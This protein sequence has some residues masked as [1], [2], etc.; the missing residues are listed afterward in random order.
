MDEEIVWNR[1][2]RGLAFLDTWSVIRQDGSIKTKV[3][4]KETH[5]SQYLNFSS[6]HPLEHKR[7]LVCTLLHP[8]EV[9]VSE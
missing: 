8:T 2:E 7:W 4:R 3:F 6:N 1:A 9:I 5:M